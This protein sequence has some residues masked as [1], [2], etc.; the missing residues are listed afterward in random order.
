MGIEK[1]IN[2]RDL[3]LMLFDDEMKKVYEVKLAKHR[4]NYFTGWCVSYSGIVLF[5]DNMLDTENNT[6]DLTIDFVYPK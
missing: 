2:D 1:L 3:Y 6:D 5:V 4:Y